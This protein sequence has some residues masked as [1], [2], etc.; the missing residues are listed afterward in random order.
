MRGVCD[1]G[2]R[3]EDAAAKVAA[4]L[5][6]AASERGDGGVGFAMLEELCRRGIVAPVDIAGN[7]RRLR[8][9]S[10]KA[11]RSRSL[12]WGAL[13]TAMLCCASAP[14]DEDPAESRS[15]TAARS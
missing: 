8:R 12:R 13:P 14:T 1:R 2:R 15:P 5:G 7:W 11:G 10:S 3:C 6:W 4:S 9:W